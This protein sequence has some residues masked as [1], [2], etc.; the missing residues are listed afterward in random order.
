MKTTSVLASA[1]LISMALQ[2]GTVAAQSAPQIGTPETPAKSQ[3]NY[4]QPRLGQAGNL[5][6]LEAGNRSS[7]LVGRSVINDAN[8]TI[9]KVDDI[10]L[11]SDGKAAYA[12]LSVGG[13]LGMGSHLVAVPYSS[14]KLS[15]KKMILP[16]ATKESLT[17]MPEFKYSK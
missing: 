7:E 5:S 2:A 11:A 1:A 16:T 17:A 9:G 10:I 6:G 8:D 3:S 14:L 12:I 15:D 4:D 13:F